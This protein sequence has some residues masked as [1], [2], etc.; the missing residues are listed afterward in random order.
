MKK[1]ICLLIL[2]G[3]IV[4][5]HAN[6]EDIIRD[7]ET[8]LKAGHHFKA[9]TKIK[10]ALDTYTNSYP[11]KLQLA[12]AMELQGNIAEAVHIYQNILSNRKNATD[13]YA[14]KQTAVNRLNA[15]LGK[16]PKLLEMQSTFV[17][18][19]SQS[20]SNALKNK[21]PHTAFHAHNMVKQTTGNKQLKGLNRQL[22]EKTFAILPNKQEF[23]A[24]TLKSRL[25]IV[26]SS[27]QNTEK[28]HKAIKTLI[29]YVGVTH[30]KY[31]MVN[32]WMARSLQRIGK[33]DKALGYYDLFLKFTTETSDENILSY[34]KDAQDRI[35]H[36]NSILKEITKRKNNYIANLIIFAKNYFKKN[37]NQSS[38][39][40]REIFKLDIE[41]IEAQKLQNRIINLG[42]TQ[43]FDRSLLKKWTLMDD[44][45]H[46]PLM[47]V[48]T[49]AHYNNTKNGILTLPRY[50]NARSPALPTIIASNMK[51]PGYGLIRASF[52]TSLSN[53]EVIDK[54]QAYGFAIHN[55]IDNTI[56]CIL[57]NREPNLGKIAVR[58]LEISPKGVYKSLGALFVS[59]LENLEDWVQLDVLNIKNEFHVYIN[60]RQKENLRIRYTKTGLDGNVGLF[61]NGNSTTIKDFIFS[62]RSQNKIDLRKTNLSL[63]NRESL[64]GWW[65]FNN[66][67]HRAKPLSKS[68]NIHIAN[69]QMIIKNIT[70]NPSSY[71]HE[72]FFSSSFEWKTTF[73]LTANNNKAYH[74][75]FF[76]YK[77]LEGSGF[78]LRITP[79]KDQWTV[80]LIEVD[81][82]GLSK[83]LKTT[84][85]PAPQKSNKFHEIIF[86]V[87]NRHLNIDYDNNLLINSQLSKDP[88]GHVGFSISGAIFSVINSEYNN[89]TQLFK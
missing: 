55:I 87:N 30:P 27:E 25:Y 65:F 39:A 38:A 74:D 53:N 67:T 89:T 33:H 86:S 8:D 16:N 29:P 4:N 84:A 78:H 58:G 15:L 50:P 44:I 14:N 75:F 23:E 70:N 42:S 43:I 54:N 20:A 62:T 80:Q 56:F 1:L 24:A 28:A 32:Y 82:N 59:E 18:Q 35:P 37:P 19:T 61:V 77:D 5:L 69:Q 40:I 85:V 76:G 63:F 68:N 57:L 66:D 12:K 83:T 71:Y 34:R 72:K 73:T 11:L 21:Q 17:E 64:K 36:I 47:D 46:R 79:N 45:T 60:N 3:T 51:Y 52:K 88:T 49:R 31:Q 26:R 10:K 48:R 13:K 6:E 2:L 41:N 81:D 7:V 22:P 9:V